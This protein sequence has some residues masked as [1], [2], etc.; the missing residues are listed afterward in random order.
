MIAKLQRLNSNDFVQVI[1]LERLPVTLGRA[2]EADI[3]VS[4]QFASR[5][6]CRICQ[7]ESQLVVQDLGS[8]WS[9][10]VNGQPIAESPLVTGDTLTVGIS[11]FRVEIEESA[12]VSWLGRIGASVK[13]LRASSPGC[14]SQIANS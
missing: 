11:H 9:T 14:S 13:K 1:P 12:N 6:H 2:A 10:L 8:T 5:L 3:Q 7:I 4:D